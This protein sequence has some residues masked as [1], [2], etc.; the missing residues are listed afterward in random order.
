MNIL[1]RIGI[2]KYGKPFYREREGRWAKLY[3][4][5]RCGNQKGYVGVKYGWDLWEELK[6]EH[7]NGHK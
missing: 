7:S 1:C 6:K 2:H 5:E 3:V 4:C